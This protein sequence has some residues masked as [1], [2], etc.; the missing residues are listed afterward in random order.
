MRDVLPE[1]HFKVANKVM[2]QALEY[3]AYSYQPDWFNNEWVN[4][5]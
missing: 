3:G 1:N 2:K 5:G 4:N